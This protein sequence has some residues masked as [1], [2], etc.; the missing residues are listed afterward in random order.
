MPGVIKGTGYNQQ[1]LVD[2]LRALRN[3]VLGKPSVAAGSV[4]TTGVQ[5]GTAFDYMIDGGVKTK[6]ANT[7][8]AFPAG[9]TNTAAAQ[10]CKL[11]MEID[12]A[13]AVTYKQGIIDAIGDKY[14]L[15]TAGLT[16]VASIDVPASFTFNTSLASLLTFTDGD[17][18]LKPVINL[19]GYATVG[20]VS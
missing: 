14:P 15:R 6:A 3:I 2:L 8:V 18:D 17:P 1:D 12:S 19:G 11:R 16:T 9:L 7:G 5:V 10:Q 13:G 20:L 4:L